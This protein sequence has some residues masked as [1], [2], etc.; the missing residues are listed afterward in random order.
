MPAVTQDDHVPYGELAEQL[1]ASIVR[2]RE[3]VEARA[4]PV[5]TEIACAL[6]LIVDMATHAHEHALANHA[7]IE[8]LEARAKLEGPS[9]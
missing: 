3:D 7:R 9:E 6:D 8:T 5:L 1:R 2:L 4:D